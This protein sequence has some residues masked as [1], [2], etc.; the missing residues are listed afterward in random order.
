VALAPVWQAYASVWMT[1]ARMFRARWRRNRHA[2]ISLALILTGMAG[3]LVGGWLIGRWC[4]GLVLIAESAG[5]VWA[6]LARDDGTGPPV[7]GARTH[8]Q[9]LGEAADR[10]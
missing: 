1:R 9:I 2:I 6:G 5:V 4:L 3:G 8:A 7:R 10:P